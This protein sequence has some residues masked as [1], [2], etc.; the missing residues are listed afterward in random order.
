[1][2]IIDIILNI[3]NMEIREILAKNAIALRRERGLTQEQVC[4]QAKLDRSY[5]WGIEKSIRNPSIEVIARLAE[6]YGVEPYELL[7]IK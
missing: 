7:M 4:E 6:V 5:L 1:M 3:I 2:L